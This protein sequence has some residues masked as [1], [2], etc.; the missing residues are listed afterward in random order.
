MSRSAT[1]CCGT[2]PARPRAAARADRRARRAAG[3]RGRGRHACWSPPSP[4]PSCAGC[5]TTSPTR[6]GPGGR[7][8]AAARLRLAARVRTRDAPFTDRGDASGTGYFS[9]RDGGVAARPG[10]GRARSRGGAAAHRRAPAR[11]PGRPP[12]GRVVSAGTGDNMGA[13]LGLSLAPGDVV[14]SVG[15]SGWPRRSARTRSPT[16][17]ACV[18]GFADATG[19]FLP[20]VVTMNAAGILDLQA[21]LLGVDHA[22][23]SA[24]ALA[25]PA[26]ANGLT[27]LPY[28]GGE[29]TPNRP[30]AVGT[31]TGLTPATT[32]A[33]LARAAFEA[34][35]CSLADAVDELVRHTGQEP[36]RLADDRRRHGQPG[37]ARPWR[38][39]SSAGRSPSCRRGSTSR[40]GPPARPPG[41]CPAR[42]SRR[43]GRSP[44][45]RPSRPTRP[46]AYASAMPSCASAPRPGTTE[47]YST[48]S[49][50]IPTPTPEDKFSF[51]LWTVGWQ[52][53]DPFGGATRAADGHRPR[54]GEAGRA[55]R[56]RR[57]LPRRRRHP[58]RQRRRDP[59]RDHRALQE[60]PGR[61]RAGGHD[62]HH[63]PV[64]PP[65]LQG[66]RVHQQQPRHPPVRAA[67]GDAQHRPGRRARREGLRRL[68]RPR[69]RGVRR[70]AGHR[71][72]AGP[73]EGGLRHPRP[74]R[75]RPGLR[76]AVRDRAEAQRAARRHPAA[77]HRPR[78]GVHQRARAAGAGRGEPGDRPRGDGRA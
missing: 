52:G 47:R 10:R 49:I 6:R 1:R 56:L 43:P 67:Q 12:P 24:L 22:G 21:A 36:R 41:R 27:L 76:P 77:D 34:L 20:M 78:A 65:G 71:G 7:R 19:G 11:S 29:R 69:G 74:V 40:S 28:Y 53:V 60:G 70:L 25:A 9:H 38:P 16:A 17:P 15:T 62:G 5:A 75:R 18:T 66:R 31:W 51:G 42:P 44:A 55:R 37:A 58:V 57:E 46:A 8:P 13:A 59:R 45:A 2:T 3:L 30:D 32:R 23:L 50:E 63:Q 61:H 48:M 14:L 73:D 26:G 68:G 33:D 35:L 39:P 64:Q 4:P 72:R 54:A